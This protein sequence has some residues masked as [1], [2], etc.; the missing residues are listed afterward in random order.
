MGGDNQ[1]KISA[2]RAA[3]GEERFATAEQ[4][5]RDALEVDPNDVDA[6]EILFLCQQR[7]GDGAGAERTLRRVIAVAPRKQWPRGD[8]ARLL[9][10]MGRAAETRRP[11]PWAR[12]PDRRASR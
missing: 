10:G 2:G 3:I 6:L 5:A 12:P 7:F 9:S 8:L 4:L 11:P 1:D